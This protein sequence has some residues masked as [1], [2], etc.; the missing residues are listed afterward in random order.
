M[1][2]TRYQGTQPLVIAWLAL[3]AL[4]EDLFPYVILSVLTWLSILTVVWSFPAIAALYEMARLSLEGRAVGVRRWWEEARSR[5]G[6]AWFLGVFSLFITLVLVANILFYGR[7]GMT[8]WRY[9]TIL[10]L[11]LLLIWGT[12]LPYIWALNALQDASA[13]H[14]VRNAVYLTFLRPIHTLLIMGLLLLITG[15]SVV[16]PLFLLPLPAYWA[17]CTTLLARQ[18]ILDIQRRHKEQE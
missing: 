15:I 7:Q 3:K 13:W 9:A 4:Y 6:R 12:S 10:W 1:E 16:F 2:Y 8:F 5:L 11:W 17:L 18:L 14:I